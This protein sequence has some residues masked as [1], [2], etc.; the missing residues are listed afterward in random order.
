MEEF[1]WD[2]CEGMKKTY[3]KMK[4]GPIEKYIAKT[5]C[6]SVYQRNLLGN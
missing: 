2:W 3:D 4:Q 6:Q 1:H 5:F